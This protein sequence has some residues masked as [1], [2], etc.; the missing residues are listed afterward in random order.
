[1]QE[2]T[3]T[4]WIGT[5][6][7]TVY[8]L[9]ITVGVGEKRNEQNS[10]CTLVK[11]IQLK[12]RAPVIAIAILDG[13]SVPLAEPGQVEMGLCPA[14]DLSAPHRVV[15]ASEEQFKIFNLPSLK[16]FCKYKLT[17]HEGSRVRKTGF[18]KFSCRLDNATMHEEICLLCLTNL[19][20][21]LILSIPELRRQLNAAAIKREDIKYVRQTNVNF[22]S[23]NL[24]NEI[25]LIK[26]HFFSGISSLTFTKAGEALYLHS[27]SELQ[28]ISLSVTKVTKTHCALNLPPGARAAAETQEQTT[29]AS[30]VVDGEAESELE[31]QN[32]S[33]NITENGIATSGNGFFIKHTDSRFPCSIHL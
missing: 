6:N 20:D 5:N 15:I 14:P 29:T 31:S 13:N 8:I 22:I 17:A 11:E 3:P 2:T 19:G 16:P 32:L 33:K 12:H 30:V 18:A 26:M 28:R 1:M 23:N 9:T 7:G 24:N 21:C 25:L 4:L 10:D 27:S